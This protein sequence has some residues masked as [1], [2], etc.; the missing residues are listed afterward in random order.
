MSTRFPCFGGTD[1]IY[2][3]EIQSEWSIGKRTEWY[4]SD[5]GPTRLNGGLI[6]SCYYCEVHSECFKATKDLLRNC[7]KED[8]EKEGTVYSHLSKIR[9]EKHIEF[10]LNRLD[11]QRRV[12]VTSSALNLPAKWFDNPSNFAVDD[13]KLQEIKNIR[14]EIV[15]A[16][17]NL[18]ALKRKARQ[19]AEVSVS[20]IDVVTKKEGVYRCAFTVS[21]DEGVVAPNLSTVQVFNED[22]GESQLSQ[23]PN[24]L[25]SEIMSLLKKELKINTL[26]E[27]PKKA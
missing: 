17:K 2:P 24:E 26:E 3:Y 15:A 13:E 19:A 25:S 4:N 9:N 23:L 10:Y 12:I 22:N 20:I 1:H 18:A 27:K 7:H 6:T 21:I 16:E 11:L 5:G 14:S 8:L